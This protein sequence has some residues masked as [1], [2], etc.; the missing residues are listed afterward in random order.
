M[1]SPRQKIFLSKPEVI[2]MI[3]FVEA[4]FWSEAD[5]RYIFFMLWFQLLRDK[6][7]LNLIMILFGSASQASSEFKYKTLFK[8]PLQSGIKPQH[9]GRS[10]LGKT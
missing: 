3:S 2:G 6:N 7:Y 4:F 5:T 10:W 8:P 9:S 1:H